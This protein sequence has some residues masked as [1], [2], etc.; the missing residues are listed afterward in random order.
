MPL[1][2]NR[3]GSVGL[4]IGLLLG[5]ALL[6]AGC[7]GDEEQAVAQ[8]VGTQ[9]QQQVAEGEGAAAASQSAS[10]AED[11]P[12]AQQDSAAASSVEQARE[13][14]A[15][16]AADVATEQSEEEGRSADATEQATVQED[17]EDAQAQAAEVQ[18]GK[19]AGGAMAGAAGE[20]VAEGTR[21]ITL[22]GDLT[23]IVYAL[24][25]EE[26]LVAR[27]T[28]SVYPAATEELPNLGFA[29]ALNAEAILALD[30]TLVIGTDMAGP[31][32]VLEQLREAG[33]E[34]VMLDEL[35]E[36]DAAQIKIRVVGEALGIPKTAEALALDVERRLA[37]V[38]AEAAEFE[39]PLRVLHVYVRRGGV[40]LV[41]GAG[42]KAE[43]IIKAA[44]GIDAAAEVGIEGWQPLTPEALVAIDPE[45][46]L[47]MDLGLAVVG[48]IEG[49]LEIP[50]MAETQAGRAR[51]VISMPDLYLLGFGPRLPEAIADLTAYLR[52]VEAEIRSE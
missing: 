27:D 10:Q 17:Q 28:S 19:A 22:F 11:E 47:V 41:S 39:R 46:Y 35:N 18:Q 24:G 1:T 51:R 3:R 44:G 38:T 8:A 45:V 36:L 37:A 16:A 13:E 9:S 15:S 52:A 25:V 5:A 4:L 20:S 2:R 42:N 29:G 40:Q 50:G 26:Y 7:G 32:G 6:I 48:G 30:P 34:V 21:L 14:D 49:L 12:E 31:P 43:A 23:E 33:V